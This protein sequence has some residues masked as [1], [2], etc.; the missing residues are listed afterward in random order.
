MLAYPL[1][2]LIQITQDEIHEPQ[3]PTTQHHDKYQPPNGSFEL[4]QTTTKPL[5]AHTKLKNFC[6]SKQ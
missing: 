1:A 3:H 2:T 5:Y 4:H 6:F